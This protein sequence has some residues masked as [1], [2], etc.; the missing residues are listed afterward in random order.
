MP[1][2][3]RNALDQRNEFIGE[4]LERERPITELSRIY[5][6]SRK[7]AYKWLERFR[8][9]GRA[10]LADRSRAPHHSPQAIGEETA[11][12]IVAERQNRPTWGARKILQSLKRQQPEEAWPAASSIGELLKREGLI[13]ARRARRKTPPYSEPL[14][15][16]TAPNQLWCADFKGWFCCGDGTRCDPFTM[17]DAYS[18]YLLR[19][20]ATEKSDGVHVRGVM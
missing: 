17:T 9:S 12:T 5:G 19:C 2:H 8:E 20:R 6:V 1:W 16:A 13:Q 14:K 18:R 4:W 11:A 7:T 15:H 3:E 10:G